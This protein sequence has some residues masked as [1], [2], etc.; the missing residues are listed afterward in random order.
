MPLAP[1]LR[2][3]WT[4]SRVYPDS[5]AYNVVRVVAVEGRPD[6][7][8]LR[9][10]LR[11]LA[12]RHEALRCAVVEPRPGQPEV[13]VTEPVP[14]PLTVEV[15]RG[16]LDGALRR[17]ADRPFAIDQAP[18]WRVGL[19]HAPAQRRTWLVL[20]M[21]HIISDLRASDQVLA[22]LAIAYAARRA[23]AAPCFATTAPSLV[24]H[25]EYENRV[26]GTPRWEQDLA[27]WSARLADVRSAAPL[28]LSLALPG[29]PTF[30]GTVSTVTVGP[31]RSA[32]LDRTLD[33]ERLTP[34]GYFLTAA[35]ATLASWTGDGPAEVLGL[36]SFRLTRVEDEDLVGFLLDTL[37]LP[38]RVDQDASFL[39]AYRGIR[40]AFLDAAEHARPTF[41]DLVERLRLP[42][43]GGRSPVIRLWFNDLTQSRCPTTFGGLPAVEYDLA[44]SWALFD[45]GLYVRRG[46]DGYRLHLVTPQDLFDPADA[47]ALVEQIVEVAVRAAAGV[48]RRLAEL[49]VAGQAANRDGVAATPAARPTTDLVRRHAV[50]SPRSPAIVDADGVLD[51]RSLLAEVARE[52]ARWPPSSPQ[53]TV[54][55]LPARRDRRS[56]IGLLACW[57]AGLTPALV[58]AAWPAQRRT[59]ALA[60][61]GATCQYPW[62]T[63]GPVDAAAVG[64]DDPTVAGGVGHIL[65]TSGT[66]GEAQAVRIVTATAERAVDDLADWLAV[67]ASDRFA[68]LSGPA[69]DPA[70]REVL[71]ALRCGATLCLPPS[72]VAGDPGRVCG[73]LR[74][75]RITVV[76]ATPPLLALAADL[77]PRPLPDLR[78][79]VSGGAPLPA[80]VARLVRSVAPAATLVNGYGC[81]ETPQIVVAHRV[82]PEDPVP[83]AGDLTIGTPLPG[84]RVRVLTQDGRAC[85]IGQPGDIWV[86]EPHIAAGYLGADPGGRFHTHDG[87]RWFRTGDLARWDGSG[88]LHLAGRM[89]RQ[90]LVN[91]HRLNLDEVEAVVRRMDGVTGVLA[92]TIDSDGAQNLRLWVQPAPGVDLR[93]QRVHA[94]IGALLPPS[95]RPSS[96]FI[97][98]RLGVTDNLKPAT[99][100]R[101]TA[102]SRPADDDSSVD[103][104]GIRAVAEMVLGGPLD[105]RTNFFD[106]GFTSVSLLQLS[107]ELSE[108]LGQPVPALSLFRHPNLLALC[109]VLRGGRSASGRPRD[110]GPVGDAQPSNGADRIARMR[111]ERQRIRAYA[112]ELTDR[113]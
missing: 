73:W 83:P 99:P 51:Y 68:C 52:A 44:P 25:L 63:D 36:P 106:A 14:V 97:T 65:F 108:S 32:A 102:R 57:Y 82:P 91:A 7:A 70:L 101:H 30:A 54:V 4:W 110:G 20:V 1:T 53:S 41:D 23:G 86:A 39:A 13:V 87:T 15:L 22:D 98:D 46:P 62:M 90:V 40:D 72:D 60:A 49:V 55:G 109:Q 113:T 3:I 10:A 59:R 50:D 107:V 94:H 75:Q 93:P 38:V 84:R 43:S 12:V 8:G 79:V 78:L 6:P 74:E 64:A 69:H 88:R 92:E 9:A 95:H 24:D 16:E 26:V 34:A 17:I 47:R 56:I 100:A 89:D 105:P 2:R 31:D 112:W 81:T 42:R 35:A 104:G 76:N 19:V 29:D 27:W 48:G 67:T 18:L 33:A 5:P 28:P 37:A 61:V 111:A 21:H 58:D 80:A 96:V 45:L 11:D 71:M 77:D 103:S 66:T 85:G